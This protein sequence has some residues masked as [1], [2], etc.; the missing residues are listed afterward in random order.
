MCNTV[1]TFRLFLEELVD[2]VEQSPKPNVAKYWKEILHLLPLPLCNSFKPH[3]WKQLYSLAQ[4]HS[5]LTRVQM[6][7]YD[8]KIVRTFLKF[9]LLAYI[10]YVIFTLLSCSTFKKNYKYHFKYNTLYKG[11]WF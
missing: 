10:F 8:Q 1:I 7:S 3:T 6:I 4:V 9:T 5:S 2:F 11:V